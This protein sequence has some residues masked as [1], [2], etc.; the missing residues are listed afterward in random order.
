MAGIKKILSI[1]SGAFNTPQAP[2]SPLPAPLLMV[3]AN[4]RTGLSAQAIASRI[5]SRQGEA[6]C[7]VGTNIDG[8]PNIAEAMEVIRVE[9]IIQAL[10]TE[11]KIEIVLP[12]GLTISAIGANAGGPIVVN[13]A[14]IMF[15]IGSGVI[16]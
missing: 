14:T 3:G 12:P 2:I 8:S 11:A 1:I 16:R 9:E 13:G 15:G 6:G 4:Q 5:I 7:V 10:I